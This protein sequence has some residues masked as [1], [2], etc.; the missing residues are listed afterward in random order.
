M[1]GDWVPASKPAGKR[2]RCKGRIS[3]DMYVVEVNQLVVVVVE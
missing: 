1:D 2:D 3:A